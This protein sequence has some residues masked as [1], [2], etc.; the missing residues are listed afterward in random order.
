MHQAELK[1]KSK[2]EIAAHIAISEAFTID[3]LVFKASKRNYLYSF[4]SFNPL[5]R[6]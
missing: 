2:T 5:L 1:V 6:N 4:I 3:K